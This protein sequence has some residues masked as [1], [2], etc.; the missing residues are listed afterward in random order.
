MMDLVQSQEHSG[1][2]SDLHLHDMVLHRPVLYATTKFHGDLANSFFV[3][4]LEK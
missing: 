2:K 1:E 4:L 3:I